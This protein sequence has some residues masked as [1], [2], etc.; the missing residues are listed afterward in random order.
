MRP[1]Y[2]LS[3]ALVLA[4][5][6]RATP[7]VAQTPT[8]IPAP[9]DEALSETARELFAKGVNAA[10]QQRWD[11][12]RASFLAAYGVKPHPQIAGNLA[13]CEAK[14]GMYRDA[15]EH[16]SI[17]LRAQRPDA[18]P[19][20]RAMADDVLREASAK[21]AIAQIDVVP[22]GAGVVLDGRQ[23]GNAPLEMPLFLEPGAHVI[24]VRQ[25]GYVTVK[26]SVEAL[27]GTSPE[28]RIELAQIAPPPRVPVT[29]RRSV[30]PGIVMGAVAAAGAATGIG[31]YVASAGERSQ[32]D[33]LT[34]SILGATNSCVPGAANFDPRCAETH[35]AAATSDAL[36]NAALGTLIGAGAVAV[37]AGA[38]FV[39]PASRISV[40]PVAGKSGAAVWM[41][42]SF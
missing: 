22:N 18:P 10:S 29:A 3:L 9:P 6:A 40:V 21:I 2:T 34:K 24:E 1:S 38:Y 28:L 17:F 20:R 19:E 16:I 42:G 30:V 8:G 26:R 35:S 12:C 7:S 39:W 5:L 23:L 27:A 4:A 36:H 37:A 14:L 11:Q 13:A 33:A 31:L 41:R 15:A 25:E 32:A